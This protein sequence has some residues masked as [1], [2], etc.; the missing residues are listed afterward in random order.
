MSR[1]IQLT[2]F[3]DIFVNPIAPEAIQWKYYL[4]Y[5]AILIII[6][7]TIWFFYPETSGHSLEQVATVFDGDA[8]EVIA[9]GEAIQAAVVAKRLS[10]S[11]QSQGHEIDEKTMVTE[12]T[13]HVE[14]A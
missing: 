13:T 14:E 6:T 7:T 10:V 12:K 9:E 3:F 8:A 4:V 5:V 2:V 11:T 1:T